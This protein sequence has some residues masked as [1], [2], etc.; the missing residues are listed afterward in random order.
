[1]HILKYGKNGLAKL[2]NEI[3]VWNI[4]QEDHVLC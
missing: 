3:K 4:M 1:M 2:W